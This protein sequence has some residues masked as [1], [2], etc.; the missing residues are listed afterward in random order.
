MLLRSL[1]AISTASVAL[2]AL[3][4]AAFAQTPPAPAAP[5]PQSATA[6]AAPEA[7]PPARRGGQMAACRADMRMLCADAPRKG[8]DRMKCLVENR[9]KASPECQAVIAGIEQRMQQAKSDHKAM[10]KE[11]RQACSTDAQAVCADAE[12]GKGGILR[13][14]RENAAKVSAPCAEALN[15]LP[16]RKR[17]AKTP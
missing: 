15:A 10:R 9:S 17:D 6:P 7:A 4:S 13:C 8:G 11:A 3:T 2:A 12:R 1:H 14:L 16:V 5:P